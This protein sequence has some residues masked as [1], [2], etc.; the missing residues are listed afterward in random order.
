MAS[1][2]IECLHCGEV[3]VI[4][5]LSNHRFDGGECPRCGYVGWASSAEVSET[6]RRLLRERPLERRRLYAA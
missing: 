4:H 6:T 5:P 2:R 1:L 3:R